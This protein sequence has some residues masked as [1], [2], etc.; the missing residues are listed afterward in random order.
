MSA[1]WKTPIVVLAIMSWM[2]APPK[3]LG[4]AAQREAFR[5]QLTGK[6]HATL[7]NIGQPLEIP[8]VPSVAP[9]AAGD[10]AT[11]QAAGADKAPPKP[12]ADQAPV[13]DEKWWRDKIGTANDTLKRDQMMGEA[14]QSKINSLRRDSVN[15]D[16]PN[17]QRK[18]REE[19][20]AALTELDRNQK[21]VTEDQKAV[22]AIQ[23]DAR[24]ANVPASWIR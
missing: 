1:F 15:F 23:D 21:I 6:P 4:E 9:P 8:L 2:A 3:S 24:R 19:L 14:L 17:K 16:D 12:G 7:T 18:A 22:S 11:A 13:K 20:Q 10:D 5:R